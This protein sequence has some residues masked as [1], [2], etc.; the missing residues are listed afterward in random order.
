MS[1]IVELDKLFNDINIIKILDKYHTISL[2]LLL[3]K[4]KRIKCYPLNDFNV[5]NFY[6]IA[7]GEMSRE[8]IYKKFNIINSMINSD[9]KIYN[10][11]LL[12]FADNYINRSFTIYKFNNIRSEK[13]FRLTLNNT[14]KFLFNEY[15]IIQQLSKFHI[16]DYVNN[17]EIGEIKSEGTYDIIDI[18]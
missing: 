2:V 3:Q 1:F 9:H 16:Y 4:S 18:I 13:I 11:Y 17:R 14:C 6:K 15:L 8:L 7:I 10:N 5:K 12:V